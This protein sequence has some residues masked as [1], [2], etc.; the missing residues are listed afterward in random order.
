M[1]SLH[2]AVR[3]RDIEEVRRLIR[4]GADVNAVD[5]HGNTPLMLAVERS[6]EITEY[7]LRHG[8]GSSIN[9]NNY[10]GQKILDLVDDEDILDLLT[11]HM[12]R[13]MRNALD[14]D[15]DPGDD[16]YGPVCKYDPVSM[17]DH[18]PP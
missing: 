13:A 12:E 1:V 2:I 16:P 3:K 18:C 5:R 6:Y 4:R 10:L 9:K 7:L 15:E 8:A 14:G 17:V 11:E